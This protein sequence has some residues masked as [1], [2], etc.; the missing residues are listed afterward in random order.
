[1]ISAEMAAAPAPV[2]NELINCANM[3]RMAVLL[4]EQERLN[5]SLRKKEKELA[6]KLKATAP[7]Q[8]EISQEAMIEADLASL[9][10]LGSLPS[11]RSE[12]EL[13]RGQAMLMVLQTF[14]RLARERTSSAPQT[15]HSAI[16]K[17]I[18][19]IVD[20]FALHYGQEKTKELDTLSTLLKQHYTW[21]DM[22][23]QQRFDAAYL[24]RT[25][26][27]IEVKLEKKKDSPSLPVKLEAATSAYDKELLKANTTLANIRSDN[28]QLL[29]NFLTKTVGTNASVTRTYLDMVNAFVHF[30]D[31]LVKHRIHR[32]TQGSRKPAQA[33]NA[34]SALFGRE[35]D[36][37][38]LSYKP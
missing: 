38:L 8:A 27:K 36:L 18:K 6:A 11:G 28:G 31:Y 26:R 20:L 32:Q 15:V 7:A 24:E 12:E 21:L 13:F 34:T 30:V 5:A 25:A 19:R 4:A 23:A 29:N 1:M 35:L 9:L 16:E 10:A 22:Y 37:L 17:N 3:D 14:Q 33:Y 2:G